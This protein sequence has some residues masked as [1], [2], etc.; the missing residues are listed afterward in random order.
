MEHLMVLSEMHL[1]TQ[2]TASEEASF[3]ESQMMSVRTTVN[4]NS[5]EAVL[6]SLPFINHSV[7]ID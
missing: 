6:F 2:N 7:F 5:S 3:T 4:R 1:K